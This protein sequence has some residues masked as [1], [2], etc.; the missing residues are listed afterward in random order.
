VEQ[1]RNKVCTVFPFSKSNKKTLTVGASPAVFS[2]K[3]GKK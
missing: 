2:G 1:E 3:K